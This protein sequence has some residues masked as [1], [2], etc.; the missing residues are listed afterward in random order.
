MILHSNLVKFLICFIAY[1]LSQCKAVID[2]HL[3]FLGV[4]LF[5]TEKK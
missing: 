3:K 1:E 2:S 4:M 5:C